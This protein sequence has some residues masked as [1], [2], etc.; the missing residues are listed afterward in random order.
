[1]TVQDALVMLFFGIGALLLLACWLDDRRHRRR[2]ERD[3]AAWAAMFTTGDRLPTAPEVERI[4]HTTEA[5]R[6]ACFDQSLRTR[7]GRV[8]DYTP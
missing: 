4:D 2:M 3:R 1:M 6:I 8:A 5:M 7:D